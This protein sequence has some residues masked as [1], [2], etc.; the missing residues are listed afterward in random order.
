MKPSTLPT[1][2][3]RLHDA[4]ELSCATGAV[5]SP[6]LACLSTPPLRS[7][8]GIYENSEADVG[9]IGGVQRGLVRVLSGGGRA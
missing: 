7:T 3:A 4:G 9:L 2:V 6:D 1:R 5:Q 8:F